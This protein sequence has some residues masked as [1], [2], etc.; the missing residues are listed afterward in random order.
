MNKS[1]KRNYG[2][3][4]VRALLMIMVV[5]H[6]SILAY[7]PSGSGAQINDPSN[8]LGFGN[9]ALYFDNFFM[10]T[11]FF[12]SGIF[13]LSG[14]RKRGS[15]GFIKDRFIR[16]MLPFAVGALLIN[17]IAQYF[18]YC[19]YYKIQIELYSFIE[20]FKAVFGK[21]VA[22]HL[23]FLWVL[24]AFDLVVVIINGIFEKQ[25][26]KIVVNNIK[27][28]ER[29]FLFLIVMVVV[30]FLLY[31]PLAD[32]V[33][34]EFVMLIEP[35]N[36]QLSR[37]GVYFLYFVVGVL[38]GA[39]GVEN[40]FLHHKKSVKKVAAYIGVSIIL[41]S[42]LSL[43]LSAVT[44]G[45][46]V[47]GFIVTLIIGTLKSLTILISVT[48]TVGFIFITMLILKKNSVVSFIAKFSFGTYVVHYMVV[49][50]L[51]FYLISINWLP[52]VKGV[53]VSVFGLLI[54]FILA[55]GLNKIPII[56]V[57]FGGQYNMKLSRLYVVFTIV[58]L[59]L[60][61]VV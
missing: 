9:V 27:V 6:H 45:K 21:G 34:N 37:I 49:T 13:V 25:I 36:I 31:S 58:A 46:I 10:F 19:Y 55:I 33:G 30:G 59:G 38:I 35:F 60:M 3:D 12:L 2:L 53:F 51:Q 1:L 41:T 29:E 48:A 11:F 54:S 16:L 18:S 56:R 14:I 4:Y 28:F 24:F 5:V 39:V 8:F 20:F 47:N 22:F 50:I 42:I 23:W 26:A 43:L 40:T 57:A 7:V 61:V 17:P 32:A 44:S 15:I 52:F